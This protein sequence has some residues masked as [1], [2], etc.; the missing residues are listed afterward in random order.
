MSRVAA[1][2]RGEG[3]LVGDSA[4]GVGS[5]DCDGEDRGGDIGERGGVEGAAESSSCG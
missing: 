5:G 4:P 2:L 3:M 1:P